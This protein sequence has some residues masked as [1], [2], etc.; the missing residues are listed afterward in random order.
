MVNEIKP[1]YKS[2]IVDDS[3]YEMEGDESWISQIPVYDEHEAESYAESPVDSADSYMHQ[4]LSAESRFLQ[5]SETLSLLP[6]SWNGPTPEELTALYEWINT[7]W[8]HIISAIS[9]SERPAVKVR[10]FSRQRKS[11]NELS[12]ADRTRTIPDLYFVESRV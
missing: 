9:Q 3:F 11:R 5:D 8:I 10:L 4:K 6:Y 7:S 12:T 1:K 2:R